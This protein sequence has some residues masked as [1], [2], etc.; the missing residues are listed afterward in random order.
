[1]HCPTLNIKEVRTYSLFRLTSAKIWDGIV[2]VIRLYEMSLQ[3]KKTDLLKPCVRRHSCHHSLRT[4]ML[5][6]FS[7]HSLKLKCRYAL[8]NIKQKRSESAQ[9]F[10]IDKQRCLMCWSIWNI[11]ALWAGMS[12][13]SRLL[14]RYLKADLLKVWETRAR[15]TLTK[16]IFKETACWR[17]VQFSQFQHTWGEHTS[18]AVAK[19]PPGKGSPHFKTDEWT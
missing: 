16:C 5:K 6:W 14:G 17:T 2:P 18:E 11:Y 19:K 13:L 9:M 7:K 3:I 4:K 12:P 10:Q 15:Q 8:T 1:M